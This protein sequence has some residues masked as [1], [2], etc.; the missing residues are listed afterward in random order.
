MLLLWNA[1]LLRLCKALSE[2]LLWCCEALLLLWSEALL[3]LWGEALLLLLLW[4]L[5][6]LLCLLLN[7]V[8]LLL[9]K[10]L[11]TL[12]RKSLIKEQKLKV[13]CDST[14]IQRNLKKLLICEGSTWSPLGPAR[15]GEDEQKLTV[16]CKVCCKV[17]PKNIMLSVKKMTCNHC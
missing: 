1:L 11:P 6:A 14:K 9:L 10:S 12:L 16:K 8:L 13:M 3:L 7:E 2:A 4:R 5:E 15:C 17:K